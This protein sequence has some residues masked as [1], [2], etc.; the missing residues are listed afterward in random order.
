VRIVNQTAA[1]VSPAHQPAVASPIKISQEPTINWSRKL[2]R[3]TTSL[4]IHHSATPCKVC[5]PTVSWCTAPLTHL[6]HR[7]GPWLSQD[8]V[9]RHPTSRECRWFLRQHISSRATS[10]LSRDAAWRQ[11]SIQIYSAAGR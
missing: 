3:I 5:R 7:A 2:L 10:C 11:R 1:Q 6:Q 8:D 9:A 4:P